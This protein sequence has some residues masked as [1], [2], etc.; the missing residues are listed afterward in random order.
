[1][2]G[3]A[4]LPDRIATLADEHAVFVLQTVLQRQGMYVDPFQQDEDEG[5]LREALAQPEIADQVTPQL[6]ATHGDLARTALT[7]LAED[8]ATA[9]LIEHAMTLPPPASGSSG[10]SWSARSCCSPSTPTS[11]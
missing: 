10:C 4:A 2:T 11:S 7:H 5:H 8:D 1:V 3:P 9:G 6:G